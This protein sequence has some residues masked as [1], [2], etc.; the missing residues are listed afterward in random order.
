M[1]G[2]RIDGN[3]ARALPPGAPPL[4]RNSAALSSSCRGACGRRVMQEAG[5]GRAC[6]VRRRSDRPCLR[7]RRR[8]PGELRSVSE[9]ACPSATACGRCG[10]RSAH[11]AGRDRDGARP[12]SAGPG[13]RENAEGAAAPREVAV[14]PVRP[15]AGVSD[16]AEHILGGKV[17]DRQPIEDLA[18]GDAHALVALPGDGLVR[19]TL[20]LR[21][22]PRQ[23]TRSPPQVSGPPQRRATDLRWAPGLLH[24]PWGHHLMSRHARGRRMSAGSPD[25]VGLPAGGVG[26]RSRNAF[27]ARKTPPSASLC[28]AAAPWAM[29][30]GRGSRRSLMA[31]P[32]ASLEPLPLDPAPM[33][34]RRRNRLA[35]AFVVVGAEASDESIADGRRALRQCGSC[36]HEQDRDNRPFGCPHGAEQRRCKGC[37]GRRFRHHRRGACRWR[38]CPPAPIRELPSQKSTRPHRTQPEDRRGRFDSGDH[39]ADLQGRTDA[40]GQ[41][42]WGWGTVTVRPKMTAAGGAVNRLRIEPARFLYADGLFASGE[43]AVGKTQDLCQASGHA[44]T[45]SVLLRI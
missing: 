24:H 14:D 29:S 30:R 26:N 44:G 42:V 22:M 1:G 27:F 18:A 13:R 16:D 6:A 17:E 4:T 12:P 11:S 32:T 31:R 20:S 43:A 15:L 39:F 28:R 2:L 38:G 34:Q 8:H 10:V 23:F 21:R 35:R 37:R 33:Q 45:P 40:E 9:A 5:A 41:T 3:A 36:A 25:M 19:A 7:S